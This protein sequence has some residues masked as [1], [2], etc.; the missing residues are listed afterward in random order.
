MSFKPF[1]CSMSIPFSPQNTMERFLTLTILFFT[2]I[3][4]LYCG[5]IPTKLWFFWNYQ[6]LSYCVKTFQRNIMENITIACFLS[7]SF[8]KWKN[9]HWVYSW[10]YSRPLSCFCKIT[11]IQKRNKLSTLNVSTRPTHNSIWTVFILES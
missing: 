7:P 3:A 5:F 11:L 10:V 4:I 9:T 2:V 1:I 8:G 6:F